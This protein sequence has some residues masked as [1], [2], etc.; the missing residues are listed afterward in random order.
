MLRIPGLTDGGFV[1]NHMV[2]HVDMMA[3]LAD[4]AGIDSVQQCDEKEPFSID[5]CTEGTSFVPLARKLANT[6]DANNL[7]EAISWKNASYSQYIRGGNGETLM[8]YSMTT[9]TDLRFTAWVDFD[10]STNTTEWKMDSEKAAF[11]LYNHTSDGADN[12]NIANDVDKSELVADLFEKLKLGWR[13][14]V[15]EI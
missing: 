9:D 14:T 12:V 11:E 6:R 13:A 7:N 8:G 10:V 4:A 3:T 5:R 1:S 2:E 15:S